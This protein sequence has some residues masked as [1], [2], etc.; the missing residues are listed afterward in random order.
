MSSHSV[1]QQWTIS[2]LDCEVWWKVYFIRQPVMTS[3]VVG[4]RRSSKVAPEKVMVTIWWPAAHP[5]HCTFLNPSKTITSEKYP[6]EIRGIHRNVGCNTYGQHWLTEWAQFSTTVLH[7]VLNNQHLRNWRNRTTKFYLI[8]HIHLTSC[9][10]TTTS[11]S[12][13][14]TFCRENTSTTSRRQ[15]MLSKSSLKPKAQIFTFYFFNLFLLVG[16]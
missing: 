9:Q 16:G 4:P 6:Q 3:S 12:I 5:T 8:H 10:P 7:H 2:Q 15:K 11:S 14:T 1:Q 13:S